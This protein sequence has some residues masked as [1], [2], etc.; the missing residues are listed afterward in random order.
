MAKKQKMIITGVSGLLGNNLGFCLKDDYT[1]LG[2]FH[3]HACAIE[4][5]AL[6]AIDLTDLEQVKSIVRE[7]QPDIIIH[8]AALSDI[9][10]CEA[11]QDMAYKANVLA[12]R[13]LIEAIGQIPCQFIFISTDSIYDETHGSL[14]DEQGAVN[15][16]NYYSWTKIEAEK[17]ALKH[18]NTLI[19]RTNIFGW[20]IQEKFSLGE[21]IIHELSHQTK[22][23]GFSDAEFS[24]I[25]TFELAKLIDRAIQK[26]IQGVYNAA[27]RTHL[28]KY[29]FARAI[30]RRF[31]L[32]EKLIEPIPIDDFAFKAKRRKFMALDTSKIQRALNVQC[33]TIEECIEKFYQDHQKGVPSKIKQGWRGNV[34]PRLDFIPYGRQ[35]I[36]DDDIEAVTKVLKSGYLTQGPKIAEFEEALKAKTGAQFAVAVNSGTSALHIACLAAG[37]NAGDEVI[38]SPNSFVASANCIVYCEGTPVF[39]D[40]DPKTYNIS[41]LA[42]EQKITKATKAVIPVHFAGASSDMQA[43]YDIV[44]QKQKQYAHKIYIIEDASQAL[45]SSYKAKKVGSCAYSDM[46]VLSFHPVKHITTAEGGA[47]LTNDEQLCHSLKRLR[48]HG[49]ANDPGELIHKDEA[50][51]SSNEGDRIKRPW[52]YEQQ[53]LGFNYRITDIQCAL[54]IS[55]IKKLDRFIKHRKGIVGRYNAA[56]EGLDYVTTPYEAD[57]NIS[58]FHLYVLLFDFEQLG[59]SRAHLMLELRKKGIQTQVHFIPIHTQPYYQKKFGYRWGQYPNAEN[60]YKRCLSIPLFAVMEEEEVG[61]VIETIRNL[62][63]IPVT[64]DN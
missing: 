42:I 17:E 27:S 61:K 56:F 44:R 18:D 32:N 8:C 37:I 43:I 22:I 49:I 25:Y 2:L 60:Y 13:H 39:A 54:G 7:F 45:G 41:P 63:P 48:S 1:I 19:L 57:F 14:I 12:T 29:Q 38:T 10:Y 26:K 5:I 23:K 36:E 46:T 31:Q 62:K 64:H 28:S 55:Q 11:H 59:M 16:S 3:Q 40:I 4:G 51:E 20:N 50:F 52:Y 9:E 47:V 33:P 58:N 30:A 15:P 53:D 6:K 21:W 24:S 34:Y 35:C